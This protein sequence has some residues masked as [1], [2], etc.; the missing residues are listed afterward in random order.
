MNGSEHALPVG[1]DAT[2]SPS[3]SDV[4]SAW[5][6]V[7]P[8]RCAHVLIACLTL[9]FIYAIAWWSI[10]PPTAVL[11]KVMLA[12]TW[13]MLLAGCA[14]LFAIALADQLAPSARWR[15]LPYV[16]ATVVAPAVGV[17]IARSTWPVS[18]P[19]GLP[20]RPFWMEMARELPP[21]IMLGAYFTFAHA[22]DRRS[23][24]RLA[25]LHA[26]QLA[27]ARLTRQSLESRLQAMQARVE[28]QFLF[29]TLADVE[30]RYETDPELAARMLDDL[31]AYLRTALPR[32]GETTSTVEREIALARAYLDIAGLRRREP[33]ASDIAIADDALDASM[34]PMV[35]LPLIDRALGSAGEAVQAGR[36]IRIAASLAGRRLRLTVQ[37]S[38][39]A[40]VDQAS[41]EDGLAAIRDR[42][43]ALY[44]ED[45]KLVQ[46]ADD[47]SRG[48]QVVLDI[49][50]ERAEPITASS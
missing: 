21:M 48:S 42:L 22:F 40:F 16:A 2:R 30:R 7:T 38:G 14:L 31:I 9:G 5:H 45:A 24:D 15:W 11:W 8:R 49:P 4:A 17:A 39:G 20:T 28:P 44:G 29:D 50:F 1:A 13:E 43:R 10:A 46:Q 34:P 3:E 19:L 32:L 12:Q 47:P 36:S 35:L 25:K 6:A 27:Q 33:L 18:L 37:D 26:A 41:G 23:R